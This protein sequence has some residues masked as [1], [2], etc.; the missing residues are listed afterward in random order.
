MWLVWN[1]YV[2]PP[3]S[4]CIQTA[5][6]IRLY[7]HGPLSETMPVNAADEAAEH[8]SCVYTHSLE[9]YTFGI[10]YPSRIVVSLPSANL[11]TSMGVAPRNHESAGKHRSGRTRQGKKPLGVSLNQ[12]AH[13]ASRTKHTYLAA[14]DHRLAGRRGKKKPIMAIAHSILNHRVSSYSAEST[15]PRIRGRL[16]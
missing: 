1:A 10:S 9:T 13:A 6:V 2:S 16:L 7:G 3:H 11:Q 12:A 5:H 14:Q 15:P 4:L 8:R